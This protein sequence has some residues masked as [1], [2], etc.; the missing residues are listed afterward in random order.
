MTSPSEKPSITP[1]DLAAVLVSCSANMLENIQ[2]DTD[3]AGVPDH[4]K[5]WAL[6]EI[7]SAY[8]CL[9]VVAL[10]SGALGAD[11][12]LWKV[13]TAAT[14]DELKSDWRKWNFELIPDHLIRELEL[15][16][17]HDSPSLRK[18]AQEMSEYSLAG[19]VED[20]L[21]GGSWVRCFGQKAQIRISYAL[22]VTKGDFTRFTKLYYRIQAGFIS[23][24][25]TFGGMRLNSESKY[26]GSGTLLDLA[27]TW[28]ATSTTVRSS[29]DLVGSSLEICL[30]L[31]PGPLRLC[32]AI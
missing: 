17:L 5:L 26:V 32:G 19:E 9:A 2:A 11:P 14:F 4:I 30:F 23:F 13:F 18:L 7:M 10:K 1:A 22:G 25:E 29:P 3:N 24:L 28:R 27:T 15:L 20:A 21:S 6:A 16:Y 8:Y 31:A 12:A